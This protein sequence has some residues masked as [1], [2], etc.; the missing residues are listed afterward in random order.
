MTSSVSLCY[1]FGPTSILS[2]WKVVNVTDG[3]KIIYLKFDTRR[4][5][6]DYHNFQNETTV[7]YEARSISLRYNL[8]PL[9]LIVTDELTYKLMA[10]SCQNDIFY[11]LI[12][13]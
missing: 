12:S 9:K 4:L 2:T 7:I 8:F 10:A 13:V 6:F 5:L 3:T 11:S 1:I